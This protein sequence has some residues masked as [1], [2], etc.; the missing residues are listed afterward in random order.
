MKSYTFI[1]L[2]PI[3]IHYISYTVQT[4][5]V[6]SY[7]FLFIYFN[8]AK[9]F[10]SSHSDCITDLFRC[11][12]IFKNHPLPS[13]N[14]AHYFPQEAFNPSF[15]ADGQRT[16]PRD[17]WAGMPTRV[18]CFCPYAIAPL[19][20]ALILPDLL[21]L[22]EVCRLRSCSLIKRSYREQKSCTLG[23]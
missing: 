2:L 22:C 7:L 15:A 12:R 18:R 10:C 17:E 8:D 4:L 23:F 3:G 5:A 16:R 9:D 13:P 14:L 1:F 11:P 19:S 21:G 20:N 6:Q